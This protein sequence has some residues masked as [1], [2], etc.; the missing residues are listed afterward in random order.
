MVFP[1]LN[2]ALPLPNRNKRR[3]FSMK[4]VA[5][6]AIVLSLAGIPAW[7]QRGAAHGG[8]AG[9]SGS[10][11]HSA[12]MGQSAPMGRFAPPMSHP[13]PMGHFS[14]P[15]RPPA[16]VG[17]FSPPLSH[18]TPLTPTAPVGRFGP[19]TRGTY[20]GQAPMRFG[21][22]TPVN[23]Q[24]LPYTGDAHHGGGRGPGFGDRGRNRDHDRDGDRHRRPYFRGYGLGYSF[25]YLGWPG[26]PFLWDSSC[27]LG[28]DAG[29]YNNY[30]SSYGYGS[31]NGYGTPYSNDPGY[32]AQYGPSGDATMQYPG[33]PAAPPQPYAADDAQPEDNDPPATRQAY[34]GQ[35]VSTPLPPQQALTIIFKDGRRLQ[36]HN[37][38]LTATTLTVLD[39]K[40]REIPVEQIDVTATRRSNLADGL[41]FRV[42]QGSR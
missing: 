10:V 2:P 19:L 13:A 17:R 6:V 16:P 5:A 8:F 11:G 3:L 24:R 32:G 35:V 39:E 4:P 22:P 42:P 20:P 1:L 28:C 9:H 25:G 37:Y 40:Y 29:D 31:P 15:M 7:A 23:Q 33:Y 21:G 14:P 12:P 38:L 30:D 36:I 27:F 18:P 26:Y 41:D 34:T